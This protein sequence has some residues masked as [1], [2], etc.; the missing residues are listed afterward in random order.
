MTTLMLPLGTLVNT[1]DKNAIDAFQ[2]LANTHCNGIN[3]LTL[4]PR[5]QPLFQRFNAGTLTEEEFKKEFLGILPIPAETF[6][7]AWNAMCVIDKTVEETINTI[8]T[9]KEQGTRFYI[10]SDTNPI[11]FNYLK[12]ELERRG[13]SLD[14]E[15]TYVTFLRKLQKEAL[16]K[17]MI[18][19]CVERKHNQDSVLVMGNPALI[20]R[21][22]AREMAEQ[23]TKNFTA[24]A[25]AVSGLRVV[26]LETRNINSD[27]LQKM[28]ASATPSPLII[29][30][31]TST[32]TGN[33]TLTGANSYS[34]DTTIR[35]S[36]LS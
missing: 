11:H 32:N 27:I 8:K 31:G 16:L 7:E 24:M 12:T 5:L 33:A 20:T 28:L 1:N 9:Y 18:D 30:T 13:V 26:T 4:L 15:T 17:K 14:E 22:D 3:V 23:Q 2:R 25:S 35:P 36:T 21:K 6:N 19:D 10:Y 34:G 29:F